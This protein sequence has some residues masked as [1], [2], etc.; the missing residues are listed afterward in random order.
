MS[1]RDALRA[2]EHLA[3]RPGLGG[4]RGG[5]GVGQRD[6]GHAVG[7]R[8]RDERLVRAPRRQPDDLEL[9]ARAGHDVERLGPDGARRPQDQQPLHRA[10]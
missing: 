3:V 10:R 9:A 8:L 5:V 6:P 7:A 4:A 2:G 1:S